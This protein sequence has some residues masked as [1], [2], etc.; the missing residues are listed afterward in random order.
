MSACR[1]SRSVIRSTMPRRACCSPMPTSCRWS[2]RCARICRFSKKSCFCPT[3]PQPRRPASTRSTRRAWR[4][5]HPISRSN[6]STR[7][8]AQPC[9][10]P[11]V[12]PDCP[13]GC[14]SAIASWSCTPWP[15]PRV[16]AA[17]PIRGG[18]IAM[19]YMP[20]TPMFHVHAWGVPYMATML[21]MKQVYPGRYAPEVF[22]RLIAREKV[23][24]THCVPTILQML[25]ACPEAAQMDLSGLTMIIGGAA[26]PR[27]L[28]MAAIERGIDVFAGYGMSETCPLLTVAQ[29]SADVAGDPEAE[30]D[31]RTCAGQPVPLVDLRIVGEDGTALPQDGASQGE[32][33]VRA[34]W[35]TEAYLKDEDASARL[36]AGGYLHTNDVG[37]LDEHGYLRI[38]DRLKDVIKTGGEWICSL[39]LESLISRHASVAEAAVIAA[40]DPHWGER[41]LALVVA[42]PGHTIDVETIRVHL[43]VF[44]AAGEIS[45]YAV[46]ERVVAVEAIDKT[47]VGKID[48]KLLR[49]KYAS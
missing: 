36:W 28:A 25:L 49:Q 1:P 2:R 4:R 22:A 33:V 21:G 31:F 18:C 5:P 19:R 38:G 41:P 14:S 6:P 17:A 44:V 13:R 16:S 46:P 23:T 42:K 11:P 20:M 37:A 24:F 12:P 47:S 7:T 45:K 35:L 43:Q 27:G 30:I 48:K 9:S 32:V 40:P 8:H 39:G 15:P 26:F 34:P 29:L 3:S 10:T